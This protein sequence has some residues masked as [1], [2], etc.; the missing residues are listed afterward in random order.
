M[1]ASSRTF[2][3]TTG[4]WCDG[5]KSNWWE[6]DYGH[7][8]LNRQIQG[9]GRHGRWHRAGLRHTARDSPAPVPRQLLH[10]VLQ[11]FPFR[12]GTSPSLQGCYREI[13]TNWLLNKATNSNH[14]GYTPP[15]RTTEG[16]VL[17]I[18]VLDLHP[19]HL[20]PPSQPSLTL[21][22]IKETGWNVFP[23]LQSL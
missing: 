9:E 18:Q 12:M 19:P 15:K 5:E 3:S 20:A 7:D 1:T 14:T 4:S 11:F 16:R 2:S 10:K 17:L 21:Q 23:W 8:F 13:P 22:K 6:V